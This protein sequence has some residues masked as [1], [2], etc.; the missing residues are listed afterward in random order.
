MEF[1]CVLLEGGGGFK[2]KSLTKLIISTEK[3]E[4]RRLLPGSGV[5]VLNKRPNKHETFIQCCVNVG[6]AM[7]TVGQH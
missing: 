4:K 6:P 1:C 3:M 5:V 2:E 7:Q